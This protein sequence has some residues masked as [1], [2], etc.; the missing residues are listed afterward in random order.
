MRRWRGGLGLWGD[1]GGD[2]AMGFPLS[3]L[4]RWAVRGSGEG[5]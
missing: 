1:E 5:G 2:A 3:V 4:A